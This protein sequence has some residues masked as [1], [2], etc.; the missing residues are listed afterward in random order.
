MKNSAVDIT[1]LSF[2]YRNHPV[3]HHLSFSVSQGEFFIIIG[4]NGS[5]KTTLMKIM[6]GILKSKIDEVKVF[7]QPLKEYTRNDL[8]KIVAIVPQMAVA[9]FPFTVTELVLMGRSPH[10]NVLGLE[11]Q[12]DLEIAQNA[13]AFTEV[14]HL[15]H[16]KVDQLSG[17]ECQRVFIARAICH[18]PKIILLD[19]PTASLDLAHQLK[20]MDLM[21]KLKIQRGMTVIMVSHDVNLAAMYSDRL[22]LLK[23]GEIAG[24]GKPDEILTLQILKETYDCRLLVDESPVGKFLRITLVPEKHQPK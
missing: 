4:P 24:L 16:R 21:E 5:G 8:A 7:N 13:M 10:L 22:L 23:N 9:D 3:L 11:Q 17:G 12:K 15:A 2:T 20:I 14:E 18:E 19:E 1:N 6:A